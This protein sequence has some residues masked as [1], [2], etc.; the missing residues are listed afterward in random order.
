MTARIEQPLHDWLARLGFSANP[1]ASR[2]AEQEEIR[3]LVDCFRRP[4]LPGVDHRRFRRAAHR[5]PAGRARAGKTATREIVAHLC[6][7]QGHVLPVHYNDFAALLDEA[8][9]DPARV[10]LG[11]HVERLVRYILS[12]LTR[13]A[14][15]D[16]FQRLSSADRA[17]LQ[18]YAQTY[19]SPIVQLD[20][21]ELIKEP[22][23]ELD[24]RALPPHDLLDSLVQVVLR[25]GPR[26]PPPTQAINMRVARVGET[27]LD[28]AGIVPLLRPLFADG[29][30]LRSPHVAFKF[31][32]PPEAGRALL[33][34][35]GL[36]PDDCVVEQAVWDDDALK[37]V[38]NTRLSY[39]SSGL[40][41]NL[42][43]LGRT[44]ARPKMFALLLAAGEASPRRL[45]R[46]C[47]TVLRLHVATGDALISAE[48]VTRAIHVYQTGDG[49]GA[50]LAPAPPPIFISYRRADTA[51]MV[52]AL[53][54]FLDARLG[55]DI[56]LD[57][58]SIGPGQQWVDVLD[59]ALN[60]CRVLL[61]M[62]GPQW[63]R[64]QD[65]ES[66]RRR[67]DDPNDYVRRE[68]AAVLKRPDVLVIPVMDEGQ[69][70]PERAWLRWTSPRCSVATCLPS[71]PTTSSQTRPGWPTPSAIT[72]RKRGRPP[73]RLDVRPG[74]DS[75]TPV[76]PETRRTAD[77]IRPL[78]PYPVIRPRNE[79]RTGSP[80]P[81]K[82]NQ[83][84]SP[85]LQYPRRHAGTHSRRAARQGA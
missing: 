77:D 57:V 13:Y 19:A 61:A 4:A 7:S 25:A 70:V 3:L 9:G 41:P 49:G 60:G 26:P 71:A 18:S 75:P 21:A 52:K 27:A 81:G 50:A 58:K 30:I 33:A 73:E 44:D 35:P 74:R 59:Q 51:W 12:A 20:L 82:G 29:A 36:P 16:Y 80:P 24:L 17:M 79:P 85:Q 31:F 65:K 39:Y 22:A 76:R 53:Y 47:E 45:L 84:E 11:Q 2:T 63:L 69:P 54:E 78:F 55:L 56:F 5:L 83:D 40:Y 48:T 10:T 32:L 15:P 6:A 1:F 46:L 66:G 62:I 67:L 64:I 34:L 28:E 38:V 72:W 68:I 23:R 14:P 43:D 37:A 8:G 42:E